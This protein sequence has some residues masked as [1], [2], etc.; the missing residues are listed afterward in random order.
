[1]LLLI[2]ITQY[3]KYTPALKSTNHFPF[4]QPLSKWP[5]LTPQSYPRNNTK[6]F[7]DRSVPHYPYSELIGISLVH[8]SENRIS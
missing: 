8:L 2:C 6:L 1:M 3:L 7:L 5:W 4:K